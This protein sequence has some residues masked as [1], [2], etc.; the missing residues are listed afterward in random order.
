MDDFRLELL[1]CISRGTFE[2]HV[3]P[4]DKLMDR[5]FRGPTVV[6]VIRDACQSL[7]QDGLIV[8][9]EKRPV[10]FFLNPTFTAQ[11]TE[12]GRAALDE[13]KERVAALR[14]ENERL[15]Q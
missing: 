2:F 4:L 14:L 3:S 15:S 5:L 7:E 6:S 1:D 12:K 8:L 9:V 10:S 11:L 13:N